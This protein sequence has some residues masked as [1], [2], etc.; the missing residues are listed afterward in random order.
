VGVKMRAF[1]PAVLVVAA[2]A[3]WVAPAAQSQAPYAGVVR[4]PGSAGVHT[5]AVRTA[6]CS[7][8]TPVPTGPTTAAPLPASTGRVGS[9]TVLGRIPT[10]V[11]AVTGP[12]VTGAI[13]TAVANIPG[14]T[15]DAGFV[16]SMHQLVATRPDFI[17]LNEITRHSDAAI[18]GQAPGFGIYRDPVVIRGSDSAWLSMENAVLWRKSRWHLLDGGRVKTV[19]DDHAYLYGRPY[20][21]DKFV[22]WT[23]LQRTDGAIVSV[24][25]A[26][27]MTNPA[28]FPQQPGNPPGT[29]IDQFVTQM[30][31][32]MRLVAQL[33][34]YGPVLMG[35]DMNSHPGEGSWTTS[36]FMTNAGYG[37]TKDR[38]VMYQF[39][40][41][42]VGVSA[43][44][45]LAIVSDHPA[46]ATTLSMNGVRGSGAPSG[47]PSGTASGPAT[48]PAPAPS[49][50]PTMPSGAPVS[51]VQLRNARIVANRA[52]AAKL[53][54]EAVVDALAAAL[55]ESNLQN[56]PA[57]NGTVGIF[58]QRPRMGWG[59]SQQLASPAYAADAFFGTAAGSSRKG[60]TDVPWRTLTV[61]EVGGAVLGTP[62]PDEYAARADDAAFLAAYLAGG[63]ST[64]TTPS[65]GTC[66]PATDV[67]T[68][69]TIAPAA[70]EV[71]RCLRQAFPT[72]RRYV[73]NGMGSYC[74]GDDR[75][76]AGLDVPLVAPGQDP[77]TR[78]AQSLGARAVHYLQVHASELGVNL[79]IFGGRSWDSGEPAAGWRPYAARDGSRT[80]SSLVKDRIY[81]AVKGGSC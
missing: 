16:S 8:P 32:V 62:F 25:S 73:G 46:L 2:G 63:S 60:L 77:L 18:A 48:T 69:G 58:R 52:A 53:P 66:P 7:T 6:L 9:G 68:S 35:G 55:A 54:R 49:G 36:A 56:L 37:Y 72:L 71:V 34:R 21:W 76:S 57:R 39:Y 4:S 51:D 26:H 80:S 42:G 47:A 1:L 64:C 40:P 31:I 41:P 15:S 30:K 70:E 22:T 12:A 65:L 50:P 11:H 81:V 28:R 3:T 75:L 29:R 33:A 43:Y 38:G 59:T 67:S 27:M 45:Q 14:R 44:H 20:I 61:P 10:D 79:I 24:I 23:T 74:G 19:N 78:S 17:L 13:T 5:A